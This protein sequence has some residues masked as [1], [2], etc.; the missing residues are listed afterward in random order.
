MDGT[1]FKA[2]LRLLGRTQAS[3]AAE[4][5]VAVRTVHDWARIGPPS[6]VSY[7]LDV[8]T[9]YELPLGPAGTCGEGLDLAV[10]CQLDRLQAA[11]S[12]EAREEFLQSMGR[13]LVRQE[14]AVGTKIVPASVKSDSRP[15]EE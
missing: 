4:I 14:D 15:T 1:S 6:D 10:R 9:M 3:F 2:R 13:W 12:P 5:G 11:V 8:L 7:L